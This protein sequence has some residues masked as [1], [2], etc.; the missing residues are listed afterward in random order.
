[1]KLNKM[2]CPLSFLVYEKSTETN[3]HKYIG[4]KK[5]RHYFLV[6][7]VSMFT[8]CH[9]LLFCQTQNISLIL[10]CITNLVHLIPFKKH[11]DLL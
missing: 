10:I 2:S 3:P 7:L 1:M 5:N 11:L 6:F 4:G 9:S 8:S